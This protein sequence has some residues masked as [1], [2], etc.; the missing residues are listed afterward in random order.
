MIISL[1]IEI[2]KNLTENQK[3]LLRDFNEELTQNNN[4]ERSGFFSKVKDF[5]DGLT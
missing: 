3:K 2:P 5:W 4:P 1:N